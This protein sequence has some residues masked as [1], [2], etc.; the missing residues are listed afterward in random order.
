MISGDFLLRSGSREKSSKSGFLLM[1]QISLLVLKF[2]SEDQKKRFSARNL[3]LSLRVHTCFSSW[4]ENLFS[5]SGAQAVFR[6]VQAPKCTLVAPGLLLYFRAQPLL[7]GTFLAWGG[8]SSDL[9][10]S[11]PKC[12]LVAPGLPSCKFCLES[13][14]LSAISIPTDHLN[15]RES[16]SKQWLSVLYAHICWSCFENK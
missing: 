16:Y 9:G 15:D 2:R 1:V 3:R 13:S 14:D 7:V 8:I 11:V 6:G 12:P 5:L 10:G 4:N